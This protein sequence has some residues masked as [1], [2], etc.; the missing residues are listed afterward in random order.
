MLN[1]TKRGWAMAL[2]AVCMMLA[3][4]PAHAQAGAACHRG[5]TVHE[6][7][8]CAVQDFQAAD[9]TIAVLYGDVMRALSAHERPQLRQEHAAWQRGR[10]AHC[11]Q[12]TRVTEQQA[13]GPRLYHECLTRAT[14]ERRAGLLRWLSTDTPAR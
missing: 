12:A 9:T 14:Q 3:G 11:K 6:T 4:A 7:N 1:T 10:T 8:A 5:G 2:G 13:D